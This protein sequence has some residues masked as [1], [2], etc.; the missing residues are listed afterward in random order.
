MNREARQVV[1]DS[2]VYRSTQRSG[3]VPL[4]LAEDGSASL[5]HRSNGDCVFL[6]ED[7]LCDLHR[8]VGGSRKPV[9]CQTYPRLLTNTPEGYFVSLSFVCPAVL[10]NS[11]E[12]LSEE[13][14]ELAQLL[15]DFH[16]EMPQNV[17][18]TAE[19]K[20]APGRSVTWDE[21]RSLE[22][23]LL[24]SFDADRPGLSLLNQAEQLQQASDSEQLGDLLRQGLDP[25]VQ[26]GPLGMQLLDVF[27]LHSLAIL[28]LEKHPEQR[29]GLME[30]LAGGQSVVSTRHG[31]VLNLSHASQQAQPRDKGLIEFYFQNVVFGKRL[32][33]STVVDGLLTLAVGMSL[34]L[35]YLQV[36]RRSMDETK[37]REMAFEIVEADV[38]THSSGLNVLLDEFGKALRMQ[39]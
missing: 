34:L 15:R 9:V 4:V 32:T 3:Y 28:E 39:G 2:Q 38:V 6:A 13:R 5:G 7:K 19:V 16:S 30:Q 18:V 26:P 36:F 37:A 8:E 1:E 24:D 10:E 35:F 12:L 33:S 23:L 14:D 22:R 17:P 27:T 31:C 29:V 21:Y 25:T 20:I 11:G